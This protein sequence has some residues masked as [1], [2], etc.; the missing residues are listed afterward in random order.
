MADII[1]RAFKIAQT[2][3]K[4]P[5]LIDIPKDI[6]AASCEYTK[7]DKVIPEKAKSP[8][9]SCFNGTVSAIISFLRT[10]V[11]QVAAI[12]ILPIFLGVNGIWLAITVAEGLTL[13]VTMY[14]LV[15]NRHRY[16]YAD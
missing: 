2:G 11:F 14:F 6:T 4:G 10:F 12:L 15:K 8:K 7:Q 13:V 9:K 5:V 1:R 16:H 3:R